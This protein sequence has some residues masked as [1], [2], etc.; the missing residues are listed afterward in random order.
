MSETNIDIET[1]IIF[2]AIFWGGG[3]P[4]SISQIIHVYDWINR[5]IPRREELEDALN[6]LLFHKL[7]KRENNQYYIP[8]NIGDEFDAFRKLKKKSKF[9]VVKMYFKNY[10]Q[11][12]DLKKQVLISEKEYKD[13]LKKYK[14]FIY[15]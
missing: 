15:S 10:R 14:E 6:L 2:L 9:E 12:P 4:Y 1:Q 3:G 11:P 8:K 5:G 13:E 7:L